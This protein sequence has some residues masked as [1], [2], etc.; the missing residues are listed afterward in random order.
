[1]ARIAV[2][3]DHD[4]V[5]RHFLAS[6]VLQ[7]LQSTHQ[8][9]FVVPLDHRRVRTDVSQMGLEVV[10]PFKVDEGR[11]FLWRRLYQH[12]VLRRARHGGAE[13]QQQIYSFWRETLGWKA[14]WQTRVM[15]QPGLYALYRR[16][17]LRKIGGNTAFDELMTELAPDIILHPTVL[18]GLFVSDLIRWGREHNVPTVFLMNSWDNPA[19]K[20]M[21]VGQPDWLVVWG[22]QTRQLAHRHL[23]IALERTKALG[24]AQ[25]DLYRRPPRQ[26]RAE[27]AAACGISAAHKIVLYAG[28]S[29][30]VKEVQ[31]LVA[32]ENA[33][34]SGDLPPCHV[35]FRPHPW[36]G[37]ISGELDFF[38]RPWQHVTIDP[39]MSDY[40][41]RSR[42]NPSIIHLPDTEYTH[43]L[44]SACDLLISPVSTILLEAVM[45]GKPIIAYLP[46]ED[47]DH[48][49][50]L[51]TMA[52]MSFMQEFFDRTDCGPIRTMSDLIA[53]MRRLLAQGDRL[54]NADE[55][56]RTSEYFVSQSGPGYAAAVE[57]LIAQITA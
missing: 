15:S 50:F 36:R 11:A 30:G 17:T 25:F 31:H 12:D 28:S 24:A 22:E 21:T 55:I 3:L 34:T 38:S 27:L 6:G 54:G 41:R 18:E 19:V 52:N 43:T 8:L 29:K 42:E 33:I 57:E 56:R 20:A 48:N 4:I 2:F 9:T 51:R 1:M 53:A 46:E 44:L 16:H 14:F 49:F 45:H 39:E 37:I 7:Q 10:R 35:L 5:I 23:G 32:I 13:N 47:I 26:S 40:Y